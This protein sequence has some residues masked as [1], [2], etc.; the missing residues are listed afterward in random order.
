MGAFDEVMLG[1]VKV[2]VR[3]GYFLPFGVKF[4][5]AWP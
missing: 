5:G 2:F 4:A 1:S 3:S